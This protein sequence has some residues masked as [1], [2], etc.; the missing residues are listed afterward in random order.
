[1]N[2]Q[3]SVERRKLFRRLA[4]LA[5]LG[6][7][8][9]LLSQDKTGLLPRVEATSTAV[10]TDSAPNTSGN[11]AFWDSTSGGA[12][13]TSSNGLAWSSGGGLQSKGTSYGVQGNATGSPGAAAVYGVCTGTGGIN[14]FGNGGND[15]AIVIVAQAN[16]TS[17]S[18]HL[19]E[20]QDSSEKVL[21]AVIGSTTGT[22]P[23]GAIFAPQL[24]QNSPNVK[25]ASPGNPASF[26]NAMN[27]S[28]SAMQADGLAISFTPKL[29]GN[30]LVIAAVDLFSTNPSFGTFAAVWYGTGTAPSFG[31]TLPSGGHLVPPY[32]GSGYNPTALFPVY[33]PG[34]TVGTQY[35]FDL[36]HAVNWRRKRIT[37]QHRGHH[38]GNLI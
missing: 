5:G 37:L 29:T 8:G 6:I 28:G 36:G 19:Q 31:A 14:I 22:A 26:T 15:E 25:Y 38:N 21:S 13:I 9:V 12:D 24:G 35:W 16:S 34:S 27:V 4:A 33:I 11:V 30:I 10:T 2:S 17:Q 23:Q 32:R 3:P 7:T 20:W 1:M 18:A